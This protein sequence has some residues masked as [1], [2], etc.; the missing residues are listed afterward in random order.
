MERSCQ[1]NTLVNT[2]A[3][4]PAI[5]KLGPSFRINFFLSATVQVCEVVGYTV[6][7]QDRKPLVPTE[8]SCRQENIKALVETYFKG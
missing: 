4:V 5:Q 7:L 1:R 8:R 6:W 3:Y 2:K